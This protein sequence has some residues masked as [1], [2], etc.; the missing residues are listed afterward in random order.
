MEVEVFFPGAH[1]VG[2]DEA[3]GV[4]AGDAVFDEVEQELSAEDQAAR[5]FEIRAHAVGVD[6]HGVDQVRGFGQQIVD[7]R[8]GVG[9]D[10]AL[11]GG[12]RDV[13]L[14]PEGDVFESRLRVAADDA[15]EAA[16]LLAGYGIAL[17]GHGGGSFLLFAEEFLGLADFGALQ[18]ADL[19]GDFI[20]SGG[21]HRERR[22]ICGVAVALDDLATKLPRVSIRGGRRFFLRV[23]A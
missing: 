2:L 21:D 15:G 18:V 19:G 10:D 23:R 9:E 22:E 16:D 20:Q 4:F 3:V 5:A 13:A 8:G 12:V 6:E 14:V 1:G 11:G 7:E 17:V